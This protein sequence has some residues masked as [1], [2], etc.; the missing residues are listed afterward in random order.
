MSAR[1][2]HAQ[3]AIAHAQLD[4]VTGASILRKLQERFASK[5]SHDPVLRL[6]WVETLLALARLPSFCSTREQLWT[7][8]DE[9]LCHAEQHWHPLL[10][11]LLGLLP[12]GFR[13]TL[14]AHERANSS[15][16]ST[17]MYS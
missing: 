13:R 10:S 1:F 2:L 12:P 3:V 9:H 15:T 6:A 4:E 16:S 8:A 14:L 7:E 17:L 11:E 5:Q